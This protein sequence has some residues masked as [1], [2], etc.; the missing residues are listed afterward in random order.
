M[1]IREIDIRAFGKLRD[2]RISLEEG[3]NVIYGL[4][5]SGKTTI[6]S[7]IGGMLYG[8]LKPG[9]KS[10][11]YNPEHSKYTPWVGEAYGG[12]L[13]L[14]KDGVGYIID[15]SFVK[16]REMTRIIDEATGE[17]VTSQMRLGPSGRI[18]QPGYQFIG[19]SSS[20]FYNTIY[21][22]QRAIDTDSRLSEEIREKMI[23]AAATGHDSISVEKALK[24]LDRKSADIGTN[25]TSRTWFGQLSRRLADIEER[26][27]ELNEIKN[28]YDSASI[29]RQELS[30]MLDHKVDR[31]NYLISLAD[32][33]NAIRRR[34][35]R[36]KIDSIVRD[37][38]E[39]ELKCLDIESYSVLVEDDLE[40]CYRLESDIR[41]SKDRISG[42][43]EHWGTLQDQLLRLFDNKER[44]EELKQIIEDGHKAERLESSAGYATREAVEYEVKSIEVKKRNTSIFLT[45]AACIYIIGSGVLLQTRNFSLLL[46]IQLFLIV[47]LLLYFSTKKSA[48]SIAELR[49]KLQYIVDLE[50]IVSENGKSTLKDFWQEFESAKLEI[51][52]LELNRLRRMELEESML[53]IEERRKQELTELSMLEK[54]L[55]GILRDNRVSDTLEFKTGLRN[56]ALHSK[57]KAEISN[58]QIQLKGLEGEIALLPKESE[59]A[60][61]LDNEKLPLDF[62]EE[63]VLKE[64]SELDEELKNL[65]MAI[66]ELDGRIIAYEESLGDK[67]EMEEERDLC[68]QKLSEL[69]IE[70]K[71]IDL[72]TSKIKSI[73]AEMHRDFAPVLNKEV[74]EAIRILTAGTYNTAKIDKML[75]ARVMDDSTGRLLNLD[76]LSGGTADQ[77]YLALRIGMLKSLVPRNTPLFFDEC[78]QQYD[79]KR[80]EA[81]LSLIIEEAR[82]RQILLFT[83]HEREMYLLDKLGK[84]YNLI[85]LN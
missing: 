79:S 18:A 14:I 81:S 30:T 38:K 31:Y 28:R 43:D 66:K 50:A 24:L 52:S 67:I 40:E 11:I 78:F 7:F 53:A 27:N 32:Q 71:A 12:R 1:L 51:S 2:K 76:D 64:L 68:M 19:V 72:A 4:N 36:A 57:L 5:E 34:D 3:L 58:K 17:D 70:K 75:S 6:H 44:T 26:L 15:R 85:E 62:D 46:F 74:S 49:E 54:Q 63:G 47:G 56:K 83:S 48:K 39:L 16:G 25:R 35:K 23:N 65:R 60:T 45:V 80:L 37:I 20:I 84:S 33:I 77:L 59:E 13:T 22:G 73:S 29:Q 21:V 55:A 61:S 42:F 69:E 8:F 10:A 41:L 9:V 82:E